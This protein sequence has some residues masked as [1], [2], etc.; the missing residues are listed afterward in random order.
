ME[1]STKF[2]IIFISEIRYSIGNFGEVPYGNTINGRIYYFPNKDGTNY[3]CDN[4][5]F[6][7]NMKMLF[8]ESQY[9]PI[10]FVDHSTNCSYAHKAANVQ[11]RGGSL[12]LIALDSN[13]LEEEYNIDDPTEFVNIPTIIISK[14]FGDIIRNFTKFNNNTNEYITI[15]IK[16]TRVKEDG[17]IKLELFMRSDDIKARNFFSEFSDYKEKLGEKL[18]FVPI[19]KY[20]KNINEKYDNNLDGNS[21]S[22]IPCVKESRMCAT[23]NKAMKIEN[24][25]RI[26]IENIRESCIYKE[27][28]Q[29]I[30]WKYMLQFNK[31]CFDIKNPL[32]NEECALSVLKNI[33]TEKDI[34]ILNKRMTQMVLYKSQIDND[35]DTFNKR[36]IYSIP[37]LYLN[38]IKYRGTWYSKYIFRSICNGFLDNANI[39]EE[40]NPEEV[41]SNKKEGNGVFIFFIIM[42]IIILVTSCY[43]M[44]YKKYI[45]KNLEEALSEKTE[46]ETL[47]SISKYKMF[48]DNNNSGS[49]L[50]LVSD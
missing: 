32:F 46:G 36:K 6:P 10:F 42:I 30:Y 9:V 45:N 8:Q 22:N 16:F 44:Y 11:K 20:S 41:I 43:L 2:I 33:L 26:L 18:K 5:L 35:Y 3:Y 37:D 21:K 38:G 34:S 31:K 24:P 25:R 1:V 15:S 14:D 19:Y 29:E 48:V 7:F 28:G 4:D 13:I 50:E 27:F 23:P 39:C 47:K 12:M 40:K 17:F 49:Q